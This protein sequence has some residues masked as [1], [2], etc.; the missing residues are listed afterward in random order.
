MS[1][2]DSSKENTVAVIN[3]SQLDGDFPEGKE[4]AP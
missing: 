3:F 4:F 2:D 1:T